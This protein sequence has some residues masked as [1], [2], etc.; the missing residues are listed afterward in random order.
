[1]IEMSTLGHRLHEPGQTRRE[2]PHTIP[3]AARHLADEHGIDDAADRAGLPPQEF[4]Q[5]FS[6]D[7]GRAGNALDAG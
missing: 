7:P 6:L 3:A 1:M 5:L 4:A 2:L